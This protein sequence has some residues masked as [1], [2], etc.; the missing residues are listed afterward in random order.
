MKN[1]LEAYRLLDED[2]QRDDEPH[3][4][5]KNHCSCRN[6]SRTFVVLFITLVISLGLNALIGARY[7]QK[8]SAKVQ[9]TSDKSPFGMQAPKRQS[10]RIGLIVFIFFLSRPYI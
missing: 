8:C 5:T 4:P 10:H 6:R 7:M 9:H 2:G 1:S 3:F